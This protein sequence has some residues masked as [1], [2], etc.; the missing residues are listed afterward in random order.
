[1]AEDLPYRVSWSRK[2]VE[3]LKE[4]RRTAGESARGAELTRVVQAIDERLRR[5]PLTFGEVYRSRGAVEEFLAVQ[6]FLAVDFA[7]DRARQFVLVRAC[8]ALSGHGT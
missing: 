6:Q 4:L 1:M 7:V 3:A 2:A 8:R 5:Q